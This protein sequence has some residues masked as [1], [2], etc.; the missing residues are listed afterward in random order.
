M[1][2]RPRIRATA[3]LLGGLALLTA[4]APLTLPAAPAVAKQ[5]GGAHEGIIGGGPTG[6]A[7]HPYVVALASQERF[8]ADRSGQFCGGAVV[9][10]DVV[11]T[12]AHCFGRDVLGTDWRD[13]KDL[14]VLFGR[15]DLSTREGREVSIRDVWINPSYDPETNAG[16][17]AVIKLAQP[18]PGNP[19]IPL[20][21]ADDT[22]D[23]REGETARVYGWGDTTGNGAYASTLRE[24]DVTLLPDSRCRQAYPGSAAGTYVPAS[25]V[26]AGADQGGRDACQGDSGGP[27]V[28]DG[29]LIGLVSWGTGCGE[30]Q[31]P[32]VYT[33]VS[34][35][36]RSVA[37]FL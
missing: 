19:V 24:A 23:Y 22:A 10:P 35:M 31:H 20:A 26:C 12:A 28:A 9:A 3:V 21:A 36:A 29:R 34:A 8:G 37:H 14:R 4:T 32:G 16:D 15:T 6:T 11:L 5:S 18:L 27:L 13:V 30:A 7:E 1:R 17:I 33:R 25:M 2:I